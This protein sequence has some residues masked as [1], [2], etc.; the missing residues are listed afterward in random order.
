MRTTNDSINRYVCQVG[1]GKSVPG[2][3]L[4][5]IQSFMSS[6]YLGEF[7]MKHIITASDKW[8]MLTFLSGLVKFILLCVQ[9]RVALA[10]IHMS[11]RGS[12]VR[13]VI[14]IWVCKL[15]KIP[16]IVHS[17][18]GEIREYYNKLSAINKKIFKKSMSDCQKIIVLTEGWKKIW[19]EIVPIPEIEVIPNFLNPKS[20]TT[21]E[22]LNDGRLNV[23]FLGYVGDVKGT[24]DLVRAI[25]VA[26]SNGLNCNL[27][28]GGNGETQECVDLVK[29]LD[30]EN[31]VSVLGWLNNE[32][33]QKALDSADILVLPSHFESFGIVIL[34][35]FSNQLPVICGS[36]GFS[37]EIVDDGINGYVIRTGDVKDIAEKLGMFT[38]SEKLKKFGTAGYD[39]LVKCYSEGHVVKSL[40]AIYKLL[41]SAR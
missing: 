19:K 33:K 23:L 38:N 40:G 7:P 2:G 27:V 26:H 8:K 41:I 21:K 1:P 10:H 16:V 37:K 34:E 30:L 25:K 35:A 5:V 15:F 31:S 28:I 12:C 39:K 4:T 24:F 18:G 36:Q 11:E 9:R 17:H 29:K 3:I 22:Y 14:F 6:S 20:R 32:E 13:A